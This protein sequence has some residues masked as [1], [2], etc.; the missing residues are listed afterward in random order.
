MLPNTTEMFQ[1]SVIDTTAGNSASEAITDWD[2][3]RDLIAYKRITYP[4]TSR[5]KII[6]RTVQVVV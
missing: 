2:G 6:Y 3:L 4:D 1:V 5:Y